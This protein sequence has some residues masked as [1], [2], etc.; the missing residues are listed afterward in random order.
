M[1]QYIIQGAFFVFAA[2][3]LLPA[4]GILFSRNVLNSAL[5]L[6]VSLIGVAGIFVLA[7]AD[8]LAIT[9]IMV[10]IGG[11]L[12]LLLYGVM[13]TKKRDASG[14]LTSHTNKLA[15][16]VTV[17]ALASVF[18]HLLLNGNQELLS[19]II[20]DNPAESSIPIIG[21]AIMTNY[22]LAFEVIAVL[23]LVAL[24]GAAYISGRDVLDTPQK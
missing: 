14:L 23:L 21:T 1:E 22:V 5:L 15:G 10:Y 4:L 2:L 11:V 3:T 17:G 18:L 20:T 19:V 7:Y 24:I 8:F 9:Q 12:I 13:F 6:L 16:V